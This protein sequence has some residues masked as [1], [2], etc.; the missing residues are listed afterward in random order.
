MY[1]GRLIDRLIET[2]ERV[3]HT[4]GPMQETVCL[5]NRG[6]AEVQTEERIGASKSEEF[7]KA[8]GLGAANR[9]LG[10][11]LV[12]HPQLVRALEPGDDFPDTIDVDQV[13]T[14]GPPEKIRVETVQELF[15]RPAVG[16]SFHACCSRSHDC[17]HA[18]FNPRIAN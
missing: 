7:A 8:L 11:L 18:V 17:D 3:R 15:Q 16:L 14:V 2:A 5:K 6:Q 10:L 1:T 4:M 12:V 9:N 13:R